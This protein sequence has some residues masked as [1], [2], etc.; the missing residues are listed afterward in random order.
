MTKPN[1]TFMQSESVRTVNSPSFS[2]LGVLLLDG[3][4][5]Y[6]VAEVATY[7]GILITGL[8]RILVNLTAEDNSH[9][10]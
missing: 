7:F 5:H 9:P 1:P 8:S 4:R 10:P 2:V 3:I 6:I